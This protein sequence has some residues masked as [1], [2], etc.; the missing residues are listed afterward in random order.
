MKTIIV[1]CGGGIAT[2][3][4]VAVKLEN[5]LQERGLGH[6]ARIE[7]INI[8][9][10]STYIKSADIYVSITQVREGGYEIP[11]FSGI[12]FLTGVGANEELEKIIDVINS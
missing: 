11:V 7:S 8:N 9:S 4:T 5:L 10:L 1:A 12:P 3:Q 6:K 2:S